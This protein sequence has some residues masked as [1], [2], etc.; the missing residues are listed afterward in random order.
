ME[1]E[2]D[3]RVISDFLKH[4]PGRYK[5]EDIQPVVAKPEKVKKS[6]ETPENLSRTELKE[7][8]HQKIL[9]LRRKGVKDDDDEDE[10]KKKP[11]KV[12][13]KIKKMQRKEGKKGKKDKK[14]KKDKKNGKV[15][16]NTSLEPDKKD[17]KKKKERK[18]KKE[19]KNKMIKGNKKDKQTNGK[20]KETAEAA[21]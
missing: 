16:E 7:K 3:L 21:E 1:I 20:P 11:H 18:I 9:E 5:R 8:L 13:K 17:I 10:E 15:K 4:L 12:Q 6:K 19:E 2:N 14:D